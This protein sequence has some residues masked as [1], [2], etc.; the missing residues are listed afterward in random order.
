VGR[1]ASDSLDSNNPVP[2]LSSEPT[3]LYDSV[4]PIEVP[5]LMFHGPNKETYEA[6]SRSRNRNRPN[7]QQPQMRL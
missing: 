6:E 2:L 3:T 7:M 5:V 1:E 4:P